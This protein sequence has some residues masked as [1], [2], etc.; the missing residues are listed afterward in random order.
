[1]S[2]LKERGVRQLRAKGFSEGSARAAKASGHSAG[3]YGY[4]P[5]TN[6]ATLKRGK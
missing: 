5:R 4:N 1:M 2:G 3:S 6:R